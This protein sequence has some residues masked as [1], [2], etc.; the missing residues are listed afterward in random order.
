MS[1][2][3]DAHAAAEHLRVP[4]SWVREQTRNEAIP[5]VPLGKYR[6]YSLEALDEW[7]AGLTREPLGE[8]PRYRKHTPGTVG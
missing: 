3:V 2:L 5:Y 7:V 8:A 6:R 4:V 1:G